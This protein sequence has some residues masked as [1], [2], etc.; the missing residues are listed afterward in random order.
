MKK[1]ESKGYAQRSQKI[2]FLSL[3]SKSQRSV[4]MTGLQLKWEYSAH[5]TEYLLG[6]RP[7][8]EKNA[9]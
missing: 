4:T 2:V 6:K 1:R 7:V 9:N 3:K 8:M 5:C